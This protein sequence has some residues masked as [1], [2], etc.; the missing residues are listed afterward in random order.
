MERFSKID[1]FKIDDFKNLEITLF[2][3]HKCGWSGR[4]INVLLKK[5]LMNDLK[6]VDIQAENITFPETL[7]GV[8]AFISRRL[9]TI[10]HG[11]AE[12]IGYIIDALKNPIKNPIKYYNLVTDRLQIEN[13]VVFIDAKCPVCFDEVTKVFVRL[14]KHAFCEEC[15]KKL[16]KC[17]MCN[18]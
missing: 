15:S 4:M 2:V 5:N 14:C 7:K 8:P 3:S 11:Y 6:I 13:Y 10:I 1:D 18:I 9:C 17:P 12:S 16:H